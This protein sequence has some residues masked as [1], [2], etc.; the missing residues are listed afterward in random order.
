MMKVYKISKDKLKAY[1]SYLLNKGYSI[2]G[3]VKTT[4]GDVIFS[5]IEDPEH[6][7][8]EKSTNGP[9]SVVFPEREIIFRYREGKIIE[10]KSDERRILFGTR[11][12]EIEGFRMLDDVLLKGKYKDISYERKRSNSIIVNFACTKACKYGFCTTFQGPKLKNG[13]SLQFIDIGDDYLVE[14]MNEELI[15]PEYFTEASEE[16]IKKAEENINNVYKEMEQLPIKDIEKK[17]KFND[18]IWN[19]LGNYC[20]NCGACNY[21]CPTCFC[22]DVYDV[23]IGNEILRIREWDSCLLEGFSRLAGFNNPRKDNASRL[24]QRFYHKL[25]YH[26]LN[27]GYYLCTGC[28][29]CIEQCP[30]NI[31]IRDVIKY[32]SGGEL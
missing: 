24:I 6:F 10:E 19:K 13:F 32:F 17:I 22:F 2:Y 4:S 14:A 21:S 25:V 9:K 11:T 30:V 16:D 29:R 12:C 23:K 7:V 31:D 27:Y 1:L 20:I 15:V 26:K 3:P 5:K 18:E 8:D 28:G